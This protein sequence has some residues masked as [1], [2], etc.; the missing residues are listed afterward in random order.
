MS[1]VAGLA[2]GEYHS[3]VT[4]DDAWLGLFDPETVE[5]ERPSAG[6]DWP[7]HADV[8]IEGDDLAFWWARATKVAGGYRARVATEPTE[9]GPGMLERFA[10]LCRAD[11]DAILAYAKRWGA[12]EI[13]GHG[14]PRGH[15]PTEGMRRT[16]YFCEERYPGSERMRP[17][18]HLEPI[19]IW[20]NESLRFRAILD[21]AAGLWDEPTSVGSP[22]TWKIIGKGQPSDIETAHR[23][24][25][26]QVN[27]FLQLGQVRPWAATTPPYIR[28]GGHDLFGALAVQLLLATSRSSGW[29]VCSAC[30]GAYAPTRRPAAGRLNYCPS[31]RETGTANR[32]AARNYRL[33][34]RLT[35]GPVARPP[36]AGRLGVRIVANPRSGAAAPGT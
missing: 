11:N 17:I 14:L 21:L 31:C 27:F 19:R 22:A 29:A 9:P 7:R 16:T 25:V 30:A 26:A 18:G 3:S 28:I 24:L 6:A 32:I 12:L 34:K 20:R 1:I 35:P 15:P 10:S 33:R 8:T 23:T 36:R 13:C 2:C 4:P 5:L